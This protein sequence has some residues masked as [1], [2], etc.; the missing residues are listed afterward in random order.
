M[1]KPQHDD[2]AA[3]RNPLFAFDFS[4]LSLTVVLDGRSGHT[5]MVSFVAVA[6]V[7][8]TFSM[9]GDTAHAFWMGDLNVVTAM[10]LGRIRL[11]RSLLQA[12]SIAPRMPAL[13]ADTVPCGRLRTDLSACGGFVSVHP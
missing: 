9:D 4:D 7:P 8:L 2:P 1:L 10:T 6:G 3:G 5:V 13:H 12:L 11:R